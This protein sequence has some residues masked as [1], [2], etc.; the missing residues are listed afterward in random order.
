M[1]RLQS[2]AMRCD[3]LPPLLLLL[4]YSAAACHVEWPAP[5]HWVQQGA[6]TP[7]LPVAGIQRN[8]AEAGEEPAGVWSHG[9]GLTR[10]VALQKQMS[11]I[12][13]QEL[14]G[15]WERRQARVLMRQRRQRG[16]HPHAGP[17]LQRKQKPQQVR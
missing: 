9:Y 5:G 8:L 3:H 2:P 12:R 11:Q 15:L 14:H 1:A 17:E 16:S 10:P 6:P 7:L 13:L 4:H